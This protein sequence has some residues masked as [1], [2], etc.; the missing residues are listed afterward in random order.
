MK[1]ALPNDRRHI[2]E[3]GWNVVSLVF[4]LGRLLVLGHLHVWMRG[5]SSSQM[6][7]LGTYGT[8][9]QDVLKAKQTESSQRKKSI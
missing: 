3:T 9:E 4:S 8:I 2:C 6:N 5:N 7:D 1:G